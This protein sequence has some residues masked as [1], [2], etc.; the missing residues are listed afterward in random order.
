MWE[1]SGDCT[2]ITQ[3]FFRKESLIKETSSWGLDARIIWERKF[4]QR[5]VFF[6]VRCSIQDTG[7]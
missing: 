6:G 4:D 7:G 5:N 3:T 2:L 1:T